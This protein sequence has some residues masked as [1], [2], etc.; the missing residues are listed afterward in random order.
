MDPKALPL[1]D[2]QLAEHLPAV[3]KLVAAL[4]DVAAR[5]PNQGVVK[6]ASALAEYFRTP[7]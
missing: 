6:I 4:E 3:G 1:T 7:D 2:E 5:E